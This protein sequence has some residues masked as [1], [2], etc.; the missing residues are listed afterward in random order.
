MQH[1]FVL[2]VPLFIF[3]V[4][5]NPLGVVLSGHQGAT[6]ITLNSFP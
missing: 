3:K 4:I 6:I 1:V 2:T 5:L